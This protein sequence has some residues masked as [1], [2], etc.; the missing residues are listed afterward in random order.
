[1]IPICESIFI[2]VMFLC[3]LHGWKVQGREFFLLFFLPAFLFGVFAEEMA[4]AWNDL[5]R[6]ESGFWFLANVPVTVG[7]WWSYLLYIALY[8]AEGLLGGS[9]SSGRRAG[10][11]LGVF[12]VVVGIL[13]LAL[14]EVWSRTGLIAWPLLLEGGDTM[15]R[16]GAACL[17]AV[18]H[19][20]GGGL[21]ALTFH[22]LLNRAW[23]NR[24]RVLCLMLASPLL[25]LL[26][27]GWFWGII[28]ALRLWSG[29]GGG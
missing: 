4:M 21:F 6:L 2:V 18:A 8:L 10:P 14:S 1:M 3:W 26:Y 15:R 13:S 24:S 23:K 9:L 19:A 28:T 29:G 27:E 25:A 5:Y 7:L 12:P 11:V 22:F 17:L 20:G 16:E